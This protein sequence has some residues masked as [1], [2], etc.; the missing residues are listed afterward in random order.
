MQTLPIAIISP[1]GGLAVP[2]EVNGRIALTPSQIFNEADAWA[3]DIFNFGERVLYFETFPYARAIIDVNRPDEAARH[4]RPGDGV[5][6]WQTSYGDAVY[7]AGQQ[8]DAALEAQLVDTYFR[9]WHRRLAAIAAD[10]RVKLVLDCH[11]MAATGPTLYDDPLKMRPRVMVG[12]LGDYNG[13]FHEARGLVTAPAE[14]VCWFAQAL[15]AALA[16]VPSLVA[17]GA[18]AA[19][20]DPFFGGWNLW[21]HGGRQQPW[22]MIELSRALYVG[23]QTAVTP[24]PHPDNK[25]ISLLRDRVWQ[26]IIQLVEKYVF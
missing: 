4:H 20:N 19:V 25:Q 2:P 26:A 3:D 12:N 15:G 18:E 17:T 13:A 9:P 10:E 14:M 22:L 7:H 23:H 16:D 24:I 21:A 8:P 1:H 6:K 11:S 5:V